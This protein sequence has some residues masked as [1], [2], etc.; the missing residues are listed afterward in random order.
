MKSIKQYK[1][2]TL[3]SIVDGIVF[4]AVVLFVC[5]TFM[6]P[7]FIIMNKERCCSNVS[8]VHA[9][10]SSRNRSECR[11]DLENGRRLNTIG[12]VAISDKYCSYDVCESLTNE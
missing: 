5:A 6:L 9:C 1:L 11:I 4:F 8:K 3:S 2:D 7:I 10:A 12:L